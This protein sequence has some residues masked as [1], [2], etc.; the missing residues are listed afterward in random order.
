MAREGCNK[1]ATFRGESIFGKAY[2]CE[3]HA[4]QRKANIFCKIINE[5][6][7]TK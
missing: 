4:E 5:V 7:L 2:Y 6:K 3:V 1:E